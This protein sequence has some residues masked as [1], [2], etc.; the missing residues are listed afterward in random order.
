ALRLAAATKSR[1]PSPVRHI[2]P[3]T[4][5]SFTPAGRR[6][7]SASFDNFLSLQR[8]IHTA[9]LSVLANSRDPSFDQIN[10]RKPA[11]VLRGKRTLAP[12]IGPFGVA[13]KTS[14]LL[15]TAKNSPVGCKDRSIGRPEKAS[16]PASMRCPVL[17]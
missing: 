14:P 8:S 9:P 7:S 5:L 13:R 12:A 10:P 17:T 3:G 15:S 11:L 2:P 1:R 4:G 16:A 6:S